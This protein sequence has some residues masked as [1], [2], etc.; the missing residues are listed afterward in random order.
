VVIEACRFI[1]LRGYALQFNSITAGNYALCSMQGCVITATDT[2]IVAT[3]LGVSSTQ[4]GDT[5]TLNN[6]IGS[7]GCKL[8][9]ANL[10]CYPTASGLQNW[11]LVENTPGTNFVKL[12]VVYGTTFDVKMRANTLPSGSIQY[13]KNLTEII[14]VST[15]YSGATQQSQISVTVLKQSPTTV[16][17]PDIALTA[18]FT[19]IAGPTTLIPPI[20]GDIILSWPD[21]YGTAIFDIQLN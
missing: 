10:Y 2:S 15:G 5:L 14:D 1:S 11:F 3:D 17:V 21:T 7:G 12:P 8:F 6:I 16:P 13:M 18:A 20:V 19:S 4:Y 9:A